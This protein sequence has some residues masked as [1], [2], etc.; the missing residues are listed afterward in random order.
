MGDPRQSRSPPAASPPN[1]RNR[2]DPAAQ[3]VLADARKRHRPRL[4]DWSRD[5]FATTR[6]AEFEALRSDPIPPSPG[7]AT[8]DRVRCDKITPEEFMERYERTATPAI[9]EVR[10]RP[11]R[12]RAWPAAVAVTRRRAC[13]LNPSGASRARLLFEPPD[14]G[15]SSRGSEPPARATPMPCPRPRPAARLAGSDDTA[16][17]PS[18]GAPQGVP[19]AEGW[20][21][22]T[23]GRWHSTTA[24]RTD[25]TL[26]R[27]RFKVDRGGGGGAR[28]HARAAS[29]SPHDGRG[30]RV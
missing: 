8:I 6:R 23:G 7:G 20:R 15:G 17:P 26:L 19:K 9:I 18:P 12:R 29:G 16:P 28:A 14:L 1:A 3:E 22:E 4:K 30:A 2:C 10:P 13:V 11:P 25:P 24:L 27:G 5:G 21:G